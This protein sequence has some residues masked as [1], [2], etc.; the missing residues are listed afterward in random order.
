MHTWPRTHT[1][2]WFCVITFNYCNHSCE[3]IKNCALH[4]SII[5]SLTASS[6]S[7][8]KTIR[9]LAAVRLC[10]KICTFAATG[11]TTWW[12]SCLSIPTADCNG[13]P[14][15]WH[16]FI[17][18]REFSYNAKFLY[19]LRWQLL[20]SA[21]IFPAIL[22]WMMFASTK[23]CNLYAKMVQGQQSLMFYT[24]TAHVG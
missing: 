15:A 5:T 14:E 23:F 9:T 20:N 18:R 12:V 2:T 4:I 24:T 16:I 21:G 19:A 1:C 17:A 7:F 11:R 3:N 8:S 6:G 13:G 10:I 22:A